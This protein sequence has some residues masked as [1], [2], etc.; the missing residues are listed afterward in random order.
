MA[1]DSPEI[2]P[3]TSNWTIVC[4]LL[5]A[6]AKSGVQDP[7]SSDETVFEQWQS[8]LDRTRAGFE[9][10]PTRESFSVEACD[11]VS[12]ALKSGPLGWHAAAWAIDQAWHHTFA[13]PWLAGGEMTVADGDLFPV[14][15]WNLER[16]RLVRRMPRPW[17]TQLAEG[18]LPHVRRFRLTREAPPVVFDGRYFDDLAFLSGLGSVSLLTANASLEDFDVPSSGFPICLRDPSAQSKLI[19]SFVRT[20]VCEGVAGLAIVPELAGTEDGF[21]AVSALV[22]ESGRNA[23]VLA[24]TLHTT[25]GGRRSNVAALVL[26]AGDVI[27]VSKRTPL[28]I[29]V[30]NHNGDASVLGS[31][32]VEHRPGNGITGMRERAASVGGTLTAGPRLAG[33]FAVVARL[34]LEEPE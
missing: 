7:I 22:R 33:G 31:T 6:F 23:I 29:E 14:A 16:R 19:E 17:Q 4:R 34:P 32:N 11:I 13:R 20:E 1:K 24:G 28:R 8:I 25:E 9:P 27:R 21:A 30:T 15:D 10:L 12:D 3:G 2:E 18:E 26:P 5:A